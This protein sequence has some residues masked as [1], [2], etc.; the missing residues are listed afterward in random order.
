MST[1]R[2]VRQIS[3]P[4]PSIIYHC[5]TPFLPFPLP[6][7]I[8]KQIS[9]SVNSYLHSTIQNPRLSIQP[10]GF[11]SSHFFPS[12]GF[13]NRPNRNSCVLCLKLTSRHP[14]PSF[15]RSVLT[16][17]SISSS[18]A[19]KASLLLFIIAFFVAEHFLP[20][21]GEGWE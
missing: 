12:F 6:L 1:S 17:S 2:P 20:W 9:I 8:L 16:L 7:Q 19:N 10:Q 15:L 18:N 21:A 3:Y 14:I 5:I 4:H 11:I 13:G